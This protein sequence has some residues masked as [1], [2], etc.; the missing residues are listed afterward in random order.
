M[1]GINDVFEDD[2]F[3]HCELFDMFLVC[4][5]SRNCSRLRAN[6]YNFLNLIFLSFISVKL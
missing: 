4:I 6:G 5:Y 3:G 1:N 2:V